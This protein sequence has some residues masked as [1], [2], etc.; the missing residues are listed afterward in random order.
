MISFGCVAT[1]YTQEKKIKTVV[2]KW[3]TERSLLNA[4]TLSHYGN[5]I[6]IHSDQSLENMEVAITDV[7]DNMVYIGVLSIEAGETISFT[8]DDIGNGENFIIDRNYS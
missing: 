2:L 7:L 1:A 3:I 4:P 8:F 5:T 6:Y